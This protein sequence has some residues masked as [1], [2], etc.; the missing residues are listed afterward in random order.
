MFT[1]SLTCNKQ[2]VRVVIYMFSISTL[3]FSRFRQLSI[4]LVIEYDFRKPY[5]P[6]TIIL[7]LVVIT[8]YKLATR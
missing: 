3:D 4:Y 2:A 5:K 6:H 8:I 7:F 1:F